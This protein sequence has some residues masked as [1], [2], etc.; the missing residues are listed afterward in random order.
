MH[1]GD[2]SPRPKGGLAVKAKV[3]QANPR[4]GSCQGGIG[5]LVGVVGA[6][7]GIGWPLPQ[8]HLEEEVGESAGEIESWGFW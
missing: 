6:I 8:G 3:R 7:D 5:G 2:R 4:S 1:F